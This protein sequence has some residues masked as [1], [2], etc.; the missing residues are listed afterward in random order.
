MTLKS[1]LQFLISGILAIAMASFSKS[2]LVSCCLEIICCCAK[3]GVTLRVSVCLGDLGGVA[4]SRYA[5][6]GE[7]K[8]QMQTG[9]QI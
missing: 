4:R 5:P 2:Y 3:F 1:G 7:L 9:W 8:V 6:S